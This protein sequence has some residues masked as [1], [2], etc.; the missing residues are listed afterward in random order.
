[1]IKNSPRAFSVNA[2]ICQHF[3]QVHFSNA[4]YIGGI[5][6]FM[7]TSFLKEYHKKIFEAGSPPG[8][9]SSVDWANFSDHVATVECMPLHAVLHRAR[10]SHINFFILDVEVR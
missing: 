6:E 9:I 4:E 5:V 10:K 2:A 7:S 3:T 8:N 1:M